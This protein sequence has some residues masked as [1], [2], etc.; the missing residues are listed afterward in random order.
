MSPLNNAHSYQTNRKQT[1]FVPL[2]SLFA[3]TDRYIVLGI[4]GI[5][6]IFLGIFVLITG[7]SL[8]DKGFFEQGI[9]GIILSI[10]LFVAGILSILL[11]SKKI[12]LPNI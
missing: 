12:K 8:I 6:L 2:K 9:A 1:L 3:K 5:G 4:L 7:I 11:S 10:I